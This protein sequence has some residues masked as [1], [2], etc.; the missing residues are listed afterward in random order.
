VR[1]VVLGPVVRLQVQRDP[2][3]HVGVGYDPAPIL[4]VTDAM[5]G[6]LGIVGRHDGSW[7]LDAHHGA[8]PARRGGGRRA[9][10][11]GF[12][13]HYEAMARRFG[14][15]PVGCAGE[16]VI[17]AVPS[18][19]MLEDLTGEVVVLGGDGEIRLTGARVASP[20]VEFTSFIAGRPLAP[21]AEIAADLEFLDA[22]MRGFILEVAHLDRPMRV[23]VGDLVVVR[24]SP[25][26]GGRGEG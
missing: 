21:R 15:A 19:V 10:S 16:N 11:V 22:G 7:V 25:P 20:C 17:V 1:G 5:I 3:R 9:L 18:R 24:N 14:E 12:T 26:G 13:A 8:H 4:S 23:R 2:V 6:P